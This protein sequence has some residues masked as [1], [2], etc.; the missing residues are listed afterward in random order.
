MEHY[1][2]LMNQEATGNVILAV[3][4]QAYSL[5]LGKEKVVLSLQSSA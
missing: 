1:S 2:F 3:F 4:S 5:L